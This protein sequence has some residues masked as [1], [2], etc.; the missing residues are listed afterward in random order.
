MHYDFTDN[1]RTGLI[2]LDINARVVRVNESAE[3]LLTTSG[4]QME[5][6]PFLQLIGPEPILEQMIDR[7]L[8]SD[9]TSS[10]H[11]L[12]LAIPRAQSTVIVHCAVSPLG[13]TGSDRP[14]QNGCVIEMWPLDAAMDST[15]SA[16]MAERQSAQREV[17][18]GLAHEIRNPLGGMRGAAQLLQRELKD[19]DQLEYTRVIIGE[20]DRLTNLVERM[21]L[22]GR[23]IAFGPVNIHSV[24]EHVRTLL[25]AE[26]P[27]SEC[28]EPIILITDYD[29]SLPEVWGS[30]EQLVQLFINV[31]R[32]AC[33]AC[34]SDPSVCLKTRF[35][36]QVLH[37][38]A[39]AR[40]LPTVKISVIDNGI[41]IPVGD[42]EKVFDAMYSNTAA[43]T[44]LGL[45]IA[46]EIVRQHRGSIH[47]SRNVG[48]TCFDI[49]LRIEEW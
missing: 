1:L 29:P 24:L 38:K 12:E 25:E 41:G 2:V 13:R 16:A 35:E 3:A 10:N 31:G 46:A 7:A 36:S 8:S 30:Y 19:P 48:Q 49:H 43:G 15:R 5:G 20:A 18:R 22:S 11:Q 45:S 26:F 34:R 6:A 27:L 21:H 23:D 17:V 4:R 32:N 33:I 39:G 47:V 40:R 42:E 37:D 9:R 14:G 28:A 44:G